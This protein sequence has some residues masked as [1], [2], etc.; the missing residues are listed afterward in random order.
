[1]FTLSPK[2]IDTM[3]EATIAPSFTKVGPAIRRRIFEW[4][5]IRE[6][7]GRRIVITGANSGLGFAGAAL[8]RKAG[9][10]VTVVARNEERGLRALGELNANIGVE[11]MLEICDLSSLESVTAFANRLL[12]RGD[13]I[14]TL[15]HNAGAL[16]NPR[17][18]SVDGNE[19]TLATHV[20]GPF[21]LT[22]MLR[23]LLAQGD[24]PRIVTMASGGL[25]SQGISLSDIQTTQD[26]SGTTAYARAK[27]AQLLLSERWSGVLS[28]QGIE[29]YVMHPGWAD[30]AGVADALPRFG[31]LM[32][33][34][35]RSPEEGA[36]TLAWLATEPTEDLGSGG[37]WLDRA[38]RP[39][40]RLPSTKSAVQKTD[41]LWKVIADLA[42]VTPT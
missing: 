28:P 25:Y 38:R 42:G 17:Q 30:T 35:L 10:T 12:D 2:L 41:A 24:D 9:A 40:H 37:F 6:V 33:P 3:L 15:I 4:A 1:M 14:D 16:H 39:E 13:P 7:S 27:R 5:P 29:S 19:L 11:A 22:E 26:Y 23:P 20:I 8:L 34:L 21:R 32:G 18:E 31:K 36:D